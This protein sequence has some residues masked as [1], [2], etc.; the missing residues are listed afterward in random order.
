ML[1]TYVKQEHMKGCMVATMAMILG[2]SYQETLA[3]FPCSPDDNNGF[4]SFVGDTLL[5][6]EG[7]AVARK[8]KTRTG[9]NNQKRAIWP[10]EPWCD[11]HW[12]EVMTAAGG[13]AIVMLGDGIIMDPWDPSRKS[14]RDPAYQQ[15]N[16]VA[17]VVKLPSKDSDHG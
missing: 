13:H 3:L 2:K 7:Y 14:L 5:V 16:F 4:S 1:T 12:C 17:G 8:Y 9:Y 6:E 11:I 10:P 15:V